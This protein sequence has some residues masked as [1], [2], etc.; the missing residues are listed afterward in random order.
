MSSCVVN[1]T[2]LPT[3]NQII[4]SIYVFNACQKE[5]KDIYFNALR[6][7]NQKRNKN[8]KL[9]KKYKD[10]CREGDK[11]RC[12]HCK[13]LVKYLT[14]AHIGVRQ[15]QLIRTVL[16]EHPDEKDLCVLDKY[17]RDKHQ[18]AQLVVCCRKCND[19]VDTTAF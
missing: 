16:E 8:Y 17:V 11:W 12:P 14:C 5:K 18:T 19:I 3:R 9:A 13:Q 15:S 2:L 1:T 4:Q 10:G 6:E 7:I